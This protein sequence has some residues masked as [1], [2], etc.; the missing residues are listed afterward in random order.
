MAMP[1]SLARAYAV[2][3]IQDH[4]KDVEFLS[5]F[6]CWDDFA[7][8]DSEISE[9]DAKRVHDLIGRAKVTVTFP[10]DHGTPTT[11]EQR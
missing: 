9:D 3:L 6:E 10:M 5:V 2:W 11:E 1:E 4:A 8:E 7:E